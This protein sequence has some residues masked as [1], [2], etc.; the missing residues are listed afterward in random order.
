MLI[1]YDYFKSYL[2]NQ[3][4][5]QRCNSLLNSTNN[6]F[7]LLLVCLSACK[8]VCIFIRLSLSLFV[9]Y[10]PPSDSKMYG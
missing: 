3:S 9:Y 6:T 10:V 5:S 4:V 7:F 8:F 2:L 1:C